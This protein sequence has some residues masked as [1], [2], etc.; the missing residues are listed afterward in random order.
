[1]NKETAK[2]PEC[3]NTNE[4]LISTGF[5]KPEN[6]GKKYFTCAGCGKFQWVEGV[7]T[8]EQIEQ[9]KKGYEDEA[10]GKTRCAVVTAIIQHGGLEELKGQMEK[11]DKVVDYIMDGNLTT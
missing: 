8:Q 9:T 10:R 4:V 5:K 1:M 3:G 7:A 11:I 2:C 6:K